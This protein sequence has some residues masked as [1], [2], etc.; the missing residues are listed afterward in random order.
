MSEVEEKTEAAMQ[1]VKEQGESMI[2]D[3]MKETDNLKSHIINQAN[4]L[5]N[6]AYEM[7]MTAEAMENEDCKRIF[8]MAAEKVRTAASTIV[9]KASEFSD[10]AKENICRGG[11][12]MSQNTKDIFDNHYKNRVVK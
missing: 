10:N 1:A 9:D 4:V 5:F 12:A 6:I 7:K 2:K 3:C 8:E 11:S